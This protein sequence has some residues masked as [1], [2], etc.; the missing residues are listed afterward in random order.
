MRPN[1][2]DLPQWRD[3][4]EQGIVA[5]KNA[6][7]SE[8]IAAF[9]KASDLNSKS[10]IPHLYVAVVWLQQ[11]TPGEAPADNAD[12]ARLAETALR[13]ALNLD[14]KNWTAVVLLGMLARNG[15]QPEEAREWYRKAVALE[16]RNADTWCTLGSL[17]L[18]QWL[19]NGKPADQIEEAI[20]DFKESVAVDPDHDKAMLYLS[21]MLRERAS[22]H[23][24]EEERRRD[25]AAAE[26]WLESAANVRAEKVQAEIEQA[27]SRQPDVDEADPLLKFWTSMAVAVPPLPPPPPPPP[28]VSGGGL[29]SAAFAN[30][31]TIIFEPR[32]Q[33][34]SQAPPIRVAPAVQEQKLITKVDPEL[35]ADGEPE[36]RLRFVVVIGKE[37]H[38][39]R[40][41][42]IDG[43]PWLRRSAVEALRQWVYE[44]TLVNGKP[45]EVV[46]EVRLEFKGKKQ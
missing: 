39:V 38:I 42:L 34:A 11:W 17:G 32:A 43:S 30:E 4:I 8:A 26:G 10:A 22:M 45:V 13:R 28:P 31:A 3:W 25:L 5:F 21:L 44:P 29:G 40:A 1:A 16:P 35:A 41:I 23:H 7:H 14:P 6:R 24:N 9:Q 18:Q 2:P 12:L 33:G 27:V 20:L 15:Q 46:T 37:G 36:S 19:R